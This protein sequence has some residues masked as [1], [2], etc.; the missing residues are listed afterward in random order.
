M[1]LQISSNFIEFFIADIHASTKGEKQTPIHYA[2]KNNAVDIIPILLA[3]GANLGDRYRF[4]DFQGSV[5][6]FVRGPTWC[7]FSTDGI[8]FATLSSEKFCTVSIMLNIF[9]TLKKLLSD[10]LSDS[11]LFYYNYTPQNTFLSLKVLI[12]HTP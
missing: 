5:I 7:I 1:K 6:F 11:Y 9:K 8:F 2:S 10:K 3:S 4:Y 12:F